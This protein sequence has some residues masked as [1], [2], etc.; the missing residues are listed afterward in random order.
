MD[1]KTVYEQDG[2]ARMAHNIQLCPDFLHH[3][4]HIE[5]GSGDRSE[6]GLVEI[7]KLVRG[8]DGQCFRG[9]WDWPPKDDPLS[10]ALDFDL[11]LADGTVS[12]DFKSEKNGWSGHHTKKESSDPDAR[13]FRIDIQS[14]EG[15]I[16][17]GTVS[18]TLTFQKLVNDK[19]AKFGDHA[20]AEVVKVGRPPA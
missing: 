14:P 2:R 9:R 10:D 8:V 15:P 1:A 6:R 18:F 19:G 7:L 16:C 20:E 12:K 17:K 11:I 13:I 3:G 5:N 4:Y